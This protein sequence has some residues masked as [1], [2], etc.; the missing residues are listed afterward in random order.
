MQNWASKLSLTKSL[1]CVNTEC[2]C[3]GGTRKELNRPTGLIYLQVS[4]LRQRVM[5]LGSK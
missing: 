2:A 4:E 5:N 3:S 1:E